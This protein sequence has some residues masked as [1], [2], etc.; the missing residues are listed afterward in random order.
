MIEQ[1]VEAI[2]GLHDAELQAMTRHQR[3]IERM[4]AVITYPAFLFVIA[5]AIAAWIGWNLALRMSGREPLDPAPFGWLQTIVGVMGL[6]TTLIIVITQSRQGK[7]AERNAHLSLQIN[8]VVEQKVAKI[9]QLLEEIRSDSPM[10]KNRHDPAAEEMKLAVDPSQIAY[11]IAERM[12]TP[13][14]VGDAIILDS[15]E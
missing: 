15:M 8:L 7:V 6:L 4:V 2:M 12:S 1:N 14:S 5:I 11:A 9:I 3:A 10:L 13:D